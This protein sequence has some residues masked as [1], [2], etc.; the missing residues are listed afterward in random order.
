SPDESSR[1]WKCPNGDLFH[2]II[3]LL[4]SRCAPMVLIQVKG[5]SGNCHNDAADML[6]KQGA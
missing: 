2:N 5:H 4:K 1:G 3:G 6:T